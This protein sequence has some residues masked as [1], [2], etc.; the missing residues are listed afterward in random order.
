[1][2]AILM[3]TCGQAGAPTPLT[4]VGTARRWW[5]SGRIGKDQ[6]RLAEGAGGGSVRR[7]RSAIP[8]APR[9]THF[10]GMEWTKIVQ[11]LLGQSTSPPSWL[12]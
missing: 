2:D 7:V 8:T 9:F 6:E 5:L 10:P 1:M 4:H 3:E 11:D 12:G